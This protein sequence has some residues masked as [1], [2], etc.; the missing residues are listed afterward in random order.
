VSVCGQK[1]GIPPARGSDFCVD[2]REI[3]QSPPRSLTIAGV[4][5]LALGLCA[6][7]REPTWGLSHHGGRFHRRSGQGHRR[8]DGHISRDAGSDA[9][10]HHIAGTFLPAMFMVILTAP[11]ALV[12]MVPTLMLFSQPFGFNAILGFLGLAGIIMRNTLSHSANSYQ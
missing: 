2:P 7:G 10:S 1:L 12:G 4:F 8:P 9:H 11:P 3:E 6:L 5:V